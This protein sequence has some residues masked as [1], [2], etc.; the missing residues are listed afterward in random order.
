[1]C[2]LVKCPQSSHCEPLQ[3]GEYECKCK[4]ASECPEAG[5]PVCGSDGRTYPNEC[6]MLAEACKNERA[7]QDG[8]L[9]VIK[10]EQCSKSVRY[11]I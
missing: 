1:M 6:K 10:E 5:D 11:L 2:A 9:V 4:P 3:G 8:G 7:T